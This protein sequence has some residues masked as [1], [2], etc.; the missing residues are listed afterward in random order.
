MN[1]EQWYFRK[2]FSAG[3]N[4]PP[5]TVV[6]KC[7]EWSIE[8]ACPEL[9][10]HCGDVIAATSAPRRQL[11]APNPSIHMIEGREGLELN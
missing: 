2:R 1:V 8:A 11:Q 10:R 9:T 6:S 3:A 4:T 5:L 7:L